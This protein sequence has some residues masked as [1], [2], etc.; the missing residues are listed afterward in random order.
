MGSPVISWL[1]TEGIFSRSPF[2]T[3]HPSTSSGA[4]LLRANGLLISIGGVLRRRAPGPGSLSK[5]ALRLSKE[6]LNIP[7][8]FRLPI[9]ISECIPLFVIIDLPNMEVNHVSRFIAVL[10]GIAFIF[11]GA[12]GY[13]S[14]FNDNGYLLG[15]FEVSNIHN[16]LHIVSGVLAIMA[17]TS[18]KFTKLYFSIF[19][20]LYLVIASSSF[21]WGGS[22]LPMHVNLADSNFYLCIGVVLLLLGIFAYETS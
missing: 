17:A 13:M 7:V 5:V 9:Y 8:S 21:K 15:I 19:G 3:A 2:E 4:R 16:I 11:A 10:F 20:F 6:R 1:E 18:F 22:L 12:V 14:A